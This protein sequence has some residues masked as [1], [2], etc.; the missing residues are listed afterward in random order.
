MATAAVLTVLP[1]LL[2]TVLLPVCIGVYVYRD[3]RRRGMN[4]LLWT[5]VAV[6]APALIGLIVY[7]LVR[8]NYTDLQCPNC[9]APVKPDFVVCP[10]CGTKLRSACPNCAT[11]IEPD[12]AVCPKCTQ[13][14]PPEARRYTP[15]VHKPDK[16]LKQILLVVILVPLLFI[17]ALLLGNLAM[18]FGGGSMGIQEWPASDYFEN[19]E[20]PESDLR[21]VRS[22]LNDA[23]EDPDH[24][25]ALMYE[26]KGPDK[27]ESNYYTLLYIPGA[28][29]AVQ[30]HFDR[31]SSIFGTKIKLQFTDTGRSD[32]LF[33]MISTSKR[34]PKIVVHVGENKINC[35]VDTVSF[36]PTTFYIVPND[37]E[38]P[39]PESAADSTRFL[40]ERVSVV[41]IEDNTNVG[42]SEFTD[43]DEEDLLKLLAAIDAAPYLDLENPIY[44]K[45][46]GSGG[47]DFRNGYDIIIEYRTRDDRISP[48]DMMHCLAFEQDGRYYLIDDRSDNARFIRSID[49]GFYVYLESRFVSGDF[50]PSEELH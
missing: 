45:A 12:W 7:L 18:S 50:V 11:P 3:A 43:N 33:S 10:Q 44:S 23:I 42:V 8:G 21:E 32:T 49:E 1:L 14:L 30:T 47:Y 24:A 41:K 46:D 4:A 35:I 13:P 22:W 27:K 31:E 39:S 34:P 29:G 15:P 25:H 40:P 19:A 48:P 28:S 16:G 6:A 37:A 2:L 20:L 17:G 36:N 38:A 26:Q 9:A 5:L